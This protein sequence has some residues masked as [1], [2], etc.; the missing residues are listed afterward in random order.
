MLQTVT[1]T[2][3]KKFNVFFSSRRRH[4]RWPRDWSSDVCSSD[5]VRALPDLLLQ[6]VLRLLLDV[7]GGY[8]R[9]P[10]AGGEQRSEERRVGKGWKSRRWGDH[11]KNEMWRDGYET[12]E[13]HDG[14][15]GETDEYQSHDC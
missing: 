12:D 7:R 3:I 10:G 13:H 5:L 4:T 9:L 1:M 15:V 2:R 8:G 14:T 11:E 6:L